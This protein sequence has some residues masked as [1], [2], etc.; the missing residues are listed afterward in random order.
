MVDDSLLDAGSGGGAGSSFAAPQPG[1]PVGTKDTLMSWPLFSL[2]RLGVLTGT[3]AVAMLALAC[4][5]L[6][7]TSNL[8][9]PYLVSPA[10]CVGAGAFV[11]LFKFLEAKLFLAAAPAVGVPLTELVAVL[12]PSTTVEAAAAPLSEERHEEKI[13]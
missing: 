12:A 5:T 9:P 11:K 3:G 4:L 13:E 2:R 8:P 6:P 1:P 7:S 10:R